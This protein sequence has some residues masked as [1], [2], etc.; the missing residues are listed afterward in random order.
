MP[1]DPARI[2]FLYRNDQ[3]RIDADTWLK[4]LRPL[5]MTLIPF[6][7]IWKLLAP[8]TNHD[9]AKDPFF[10]PLTI[11]AYAYAILYAF[12]VIFVAISYVNLSA[13][14][15]R[16]RALFPPLGLASLAP[17]LGLL[18]GAAH[19]LQPRVS[20]SMSIWWVWGIDA[21]LITSVFWTIFELALKPSR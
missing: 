14:R 5:A 15:F 4:G 10:P 12:V 2:H 19:W 1:I 6:I 20:E 13:K 11:A 9:I 16:D 7:L 18:T 8:Y 21:I 3:G 17:F